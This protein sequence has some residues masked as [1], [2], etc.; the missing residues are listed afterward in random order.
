MC[1]SNKFGI[2]VE[3]VMNYLDITDRF[4]LEKRLRQNYKLNEA[5]LTEEAILETYTILDSI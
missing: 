2:S 3:K 1:E 4:K 5:N